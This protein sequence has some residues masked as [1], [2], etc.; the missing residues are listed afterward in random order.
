MLGRPEL[1]AVRE[2]VV[3]ERS[4]LR[5]V[6]N[7]VGTTGDAEPETVLH[8]GRYRARVID[9][10]EGALAHT[11]LQQAQRLRGLCFGRPGLDAEALDTRCRHLLVEDQASGRLV[12]CC[13][14]L[15]LPDGGH[16]GVSYA[17]Q[18]Y[19]LTPLQ[20]RSGPLLEL[21]RFCIHPDWQDADILRLAWGALTA[22]VDQ[23]GVELLFGCSSFRCTD[24]APYSQALALLRLRHQAPLGQ[25]VGVRA[26]EVLELAA[27][28]LPRV[29]G[30]QA[31]QQMPPLLRSYLMMGGWVS[32]HVVI[33]RDLDTLHL[34]TA[35]EIAAIPA[36]RKR[37]LRAVAGGFASHGG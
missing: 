37:L 12:C 4:V 21:G 25:G 23:N 5:D 32:D 13:R 16:L 10:V 9:G 2:P 29:D 20:S 8:G 30:K 28:D 3:G 17:A 14:L 26:A 34:F 1:F 15:L 36:A 6:I 19:D 27:M 24:P 33:D 11:D 35:V 18:R 22:F 31:L 7:P